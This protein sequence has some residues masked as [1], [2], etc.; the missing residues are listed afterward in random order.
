MHNE[1]LE[2]LFKFLKPKIGDNNFRDWFSK[3]NIVYDNGY[4]LTF[5][6]EFIYNW[7]KQNYSSLIKDYEKSAGIELKLT[8]NIKNIEQQEKIENVAS[9]INT[10]FTF[11]NFIVA[12]CN[13]IAYEAAFRVATSNEVVFNPLF[14]YGNVGLGK[15]HLMHAIA[16][17]R[18]KQ[19]PNQKISY[20]S[21]E[22][23]MNNFINALRTKNIMTFKEE[24]RS[25]DIL[26]IDDFQFLGSKDATQEEFF[27]TFNSLLE[28]KKQL[29]IC[30][31]QP[32]Y[33]LPGVEMRLKSRLGWGLVVDIHPAT[34]ELK[35]SI[36]QAKAKK[37]NI[38][39]EQEV[40][41]LISQKITS[42]IRELEGAF[43]RV[44]KYAEWMK[45]PIT[46]DLVHNILHNTYEQQKKS[47][48]EIISILCN[49]LNISLK[50]IQS[51][52]RKR[53]IARARQKIIY[54]L[55]I[56]TGA[57]YMQIAKLL[58]GKDHTSIMYAEKK[59]K[60]LIKTD[61]KFCEEI[62]YL[63]ECIS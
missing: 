13:Q 46:Q 41:N 8:H 54:L 61:A 17:H 47:T 28:Q 57:S 12:N 2:S 45:K 55:K 25:T 18:K 44:T 24:F 20:L 43:L 53:E 22:Q 49:K 48:E 39:I 36:L 42:S 62:N 19:F 14:L 29:I 58:G 51:P 34:Y 40:I 33:S 7:V 1:L 60:D 9:N 63:K 21:S 16:N 26:L 37:M 52:N 31:D 11:E 59:A 50:T 6:N 30:A 23:F 3:S 56:I 35:V 5:P 38:N 10:E 32:P 27:H 15:T 4:T